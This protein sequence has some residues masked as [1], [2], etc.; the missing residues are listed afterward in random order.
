M[1]Y[2]IFDLELN[3][4]MYKSKLPMEII[5]IGAVKLNERL[6]EVDRFQSFVKPRLLVKLA[7]TIKRKTKI[8]QVDIN[9]AHPLPQVLT[10]FRKFIGAEY[11]LIAWGPDDLRHLRT[12][13]EFNKLDVEW[14]QNYFDL[15]KAYMN[16]HKLPSQPAL[17]NVL[18]ELSI[19][20]YGNCHRGLDDALNTA[21]VFTKIFGE[22]VKSLPN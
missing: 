12:N 20:E 3:C 22:I 5:E 19:E 21:T 8:E 7:P 13:C 18:T 11:T 14:I 15:Q 10:H 6:E 1:N 4:R 2:I 16:L 9:N 17:K